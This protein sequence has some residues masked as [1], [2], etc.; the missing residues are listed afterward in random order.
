MEAPPFAQLTDREREVLDR[1]AAGFDNAAIARALFLSEKTVRNYVSL[2]MA[3][4]HAGSRA[5]AIVLARSA[6]LGLDQ[7]APGGQPQSR[8]R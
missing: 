7:P 1:V 2:V 6:G 8:R 3:K 5:E 4:I